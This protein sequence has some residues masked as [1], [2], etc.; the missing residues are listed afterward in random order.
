[1]STNRTL[2]SSNKKMSHSEPIAI[3]RNPVQTAVNP[4]DSREIVW[5]LGHTL[6]RWWLLA[7]FMGLVTATGAS[8]I[9]FL[10]FRPEYKASMWLQI[11]ARAPYIV[12]P[13]KDDSGQFIENQTQLIR[14]RLVLDSLLNDP[15]IASMEELAD[16]ADK[17]DELARRLSV[18]PEL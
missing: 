9:V 4:K 6:R 18:R 1:M 2:D 15:K 3:I 10:T 16:S 7:I 13:D 12:F 8:A 17:I 11:Y 14:S 5:L